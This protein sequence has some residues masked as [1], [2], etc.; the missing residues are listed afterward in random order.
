MASVDGLITGMDTTSIISQLMQLEAQPQ[1]RL[2][3]KVSEHQREQSAYQQLNARMLAIH[4]A[5][6]SLTKDNA[7]QVVKATS[8]NAA[9]TVSA[10]TATAT[11]SVTFDVDRLASAH[12]VTSKVPASGSMITGSLSLTIGGT[13]TPLT[14]TTDTAQGVADAVNKAKL[15]VQATVLNTTDGQVLQFASTTTGAAQEFTVNGLTESTSVLS[16]AIDAKITIGTVGAGGYSM[17]SKDNTFT[18]LLSGVT[19]KATA[20]ATKVT[21]ASAPDADA[22]ANAVSSLVSSIN[23]TVGQ[24]NSLTAYDPRSKS[25]AVLNGNGIARDLRNQLQSGISNGVDGYGSL[26]ALGVKLDRGGNLSFDK[27]KF[28][29]AYQADP[30]KAQK[31]VQTGFAETYRELGV[32]ATDATK[33]RLTL[34]VQG[35]DTALRRLNSEIDDWDTR[36]AARRVAIQRQYT[37]LETTLGRL[38]DQSSW[39]A[40]QLASL[41]TSS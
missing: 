29:A 16:Q 14:L 41:P 33:G 24:I 6:E 32:D 2:K 10:S 30:A 25:A 34:A 8:D 36:L 22:I 28:L 18:G 35:Q 11:G 3:V 38:K 9:V 12:V 31:A 26:S 40:G 20:P 13:T 19:I 27:A 4:T 23:A 5:A 15:G 39:L 37:N 1:T 7:W 21:V 17:T